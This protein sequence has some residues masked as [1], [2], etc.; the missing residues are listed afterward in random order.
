[1]EEGAHCPE[2]YTKFCKNGFNLNNPPHEGTKK[3]NFQI[4]NSQVLNVVP[5]WQKN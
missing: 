5:S 1:M 4:L 3:R 2:F